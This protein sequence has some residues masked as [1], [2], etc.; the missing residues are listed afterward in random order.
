MSPRSH[1]YPA[2]GTEAATLAAER[3]ESRAMAAGADAPRE[4]VGQDAAAEGGAELAHDEA[5]QGARAGAA[6]RRER[7]LSRCSAR[8]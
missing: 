6:P 5:G 4:A 2:T 7:K 3:G 1:A 8:S